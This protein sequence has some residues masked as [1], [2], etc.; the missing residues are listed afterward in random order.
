MKLEKPVVIIEKSLSAKQRLVEALRPFCPPSDEKIK[1]VKDPSDALKI[2]KDLAVI[3][4]GVDLVISDLFLNEDMNICGLVREMEK[5][6][7]LWN[8]PLVVYT[9]ETE[10]AVYNNIRKDIVHLPFR[11]LP[12]S[13]TVDAIGEAISGLMA[14]KVENRH[15]LELETKLSAFRQTK[16][17]SLLPTALQMID[18]CHKE[19]PAHCGPARMN[20]LKGKLYF[21]FWKLRNQDMESLVGEL[22]KLSPSDPAFARTE[23]SVSNLASEIR[24]LKNS[25]ERYLLAAYHLEPESWECLHSFYHFYMEDGEFKKA[26]EYLSRL[27]EI[28]PTKTEYFF[29]MGK[30]HEFEGNFSNAIQCYLDAFHSTLEEGVGNFDEN[31]V[32]EVIDASLNVGREIMNE[33]GLAH[34]EAGKLEPGS[35]DHAKA[36]ML[37]KN[38]AQIRSALLTLA[39]KHPKNADYLNKIGI[40]YRR[41][42]D[43]P[44]AIDMYSNA[45]E[46][47]PGNPRIR[48]NQAVVLALC[49]TWDQALNEA[50]KAGTLNDDPEDAKAISSLMDILGKKDQ[51]R[52]LKILS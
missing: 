24:E 43:Y 29:R 9:N 6:P 15:Y 30:I 37:R 41:A 4:E 19:H 23:K 11:M 5:I 33:I 12:K 31:D 3:G 46:I 28:F 22:Q 26:K 17:I 38:N 42:G 48:V 7:S 13:S 45:L 14:Y 50:K 16:N 21:E 40:T 51:K 34:I 8:T 20:L 2:I 35:K 25:A 27:V 44:N 47:D 49:G 52:L 1:K 10:E 36:L 32:M 18:K 39:V